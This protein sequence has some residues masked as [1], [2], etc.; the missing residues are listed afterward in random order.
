MTRGLL[1][2]GLLSGLTC[3]GR[4]AAGQ[5]VAG[6]AATADITPLEPV[7]ARGV[8]HIAHFRGSR[9][10]A[11]RQRAGVGVA[12]EGD[13][14]LDAAVMI[15]CDLVIISQEL[16]QAVIEATR[17]RLPDFDLQKM[18]LNATHTHT[19]PATESRRVR[20]P[21]DGSHATGRL[22]RVRRG[23]DGRGGRQGRG[24]GGSRAA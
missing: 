1:V 2:V 19:G 13:R 20:H 18:F 15:S 8:D 16:S 17:R 21:R 4:A 14:S 12:R 7:V 10:A 5:R 3:A 11:H 23:A 9:Y 24:P 6:S 22:L